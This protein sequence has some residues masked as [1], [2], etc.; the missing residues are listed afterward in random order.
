MNLAAMPYPSKYPGLDRCGVGHWSILILGPHEAVLRHQSLAGLEAEEIAE[1][2]AKLVEQ[3]HAVAHFL[4]VVR[5]DR[6]FIRVEVRGSALDFR[7]AQIEIGEVVGDDACSLPRR[8]DWRADS[9][10]TGLQA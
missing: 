5:P 3:P 2:E 4:L 7:F 8:S 1:I 6:G 9:R 10:A